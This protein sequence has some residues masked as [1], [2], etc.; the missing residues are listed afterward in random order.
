MEE[1]RKVRKRLYALPV[2]TLL[3]MMILMLYSH[4][5]V[6]AEDI[7]YPIAIKDEKVSKQ[8]MNDVFKDGGR[9]KFTPANEKE[10]AKLTLT[11]ATLESTN[12]VIDIDAMDGGLE[13]ICVGNNQIKS[14]EGSGIIA[15]NCNIRISGEGTLKIN[16]EIEAGVKS[17]SSIEFGCK[18]ITIN[19]SKDT[20]VKGSNIIITEGTLQVSASKYGIDGSAV[21]CGGISYIGGKYKAF[22]ENPDVSKY[23][24]GQ[25]LC[26]D[27]SSSTSPW[28]NQSELSNYR[29]V[30]VIPMIYNE[31][32]IPEN[33]TVAEGATPISTVTVPAGVSAEVAWTYY[34]DWKST[35][36]L[37]GTF[38]KETAYVCTITLKVDAKKVSNDV[39]IYVNNQMVSYSSEDSINEGKRIFKVQLFFDNNSENKY[40]K[41]GSCGDSC[42][43]NYNTNTKVLN[44]I[45][46]G[47]MRDYTSS[48]LA[49]ELPWYEYKD[50][51]TKVIIA[52]G[53][54]YIGENC[55]SSCSNLQ[56]VEFENG[57]VLNEIGE[58]AF[59]N[60][61]KLNNIG[62][63]PNTV[64]KLGVRAFYN[65]SSLS[66]FSMNTASK[67]TKIES[68]CFN[69]CRQL[70]EI[71]LPLS[72][73]SIGSSAFAHCTSLSNIEYVG[74]YYDWNK[75]SLGS[76]WFN[77]SIK[78]N[79][80]DNEIKSEH[81]TLS[82]YSYIY[83]GT[84]IKPSVTVT[85]NGKR[86][87]SYYDYNTVYSYNKDAG[88]A[89]VTISGRGNYKGSTQ[90][91]FTILQRDISNLS[92]YLPVS[93]YRADG[94]E[95][96]PY[97]VIKNG[98][99]LLTQNRDYCLTYSNNLLEGTGHIYIEGIGNYC[100]MTERTF[101]I[102][103]KDMAQLKLIL[104]QSSFV[105]DGA[106]KTPV[107]SV[108]DG[109]TTLTKDVDYSVTYTNN[110][111]AGTG[112]ATVTGRGKYAGTV[113]LPFKIAPKNFE[114]TSVSIKTLKYVYDG[115]AKCP[116]VTVKDGYKLLGKDTDYTIEYSNNMKPGTAYVKVIGKGNYS[117][118]KKI[119][120]T[121]EGRKVSDLDIELEEIVYDYTGKAIK[122]KVTVKDGAQT[123]KKGNDYSVKYSDNTDAGKA[124][125]TITGLGRYT[126][127]VK[128]T[129]IINPC[130][131]PTPTLFE[132]KFVYDGK[133]KTP[134]LL[135]GNL[136]LEEDVDY[137]VTLSSG[138][139]KVGTYTVFVEGTGNYTGS[140]F[141][142]FSIIPKST[143]TISITPRYKGFSMTWK[144]QPSQT[145]GYQI[146][147]S[148]YRNFKKYKSVKISDNSTTSQKITGLKRNRKCY[149]R[150]RT[151]KVVSGKTFYSNWSSVKTVT[152]K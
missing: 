84:Y 79:A 141:L 52:K 67:L 55:F 68:G 92:I 60:D 20:G 86:L 130:A 24:D 133:V 85:I 132:D 137:T 136:E 28:D 126:G 12:D 149:V 152:T 105:Y 102:T 37:V 71:R 50:S 101:Y 108:S 129:F 3:C 109:S 103:S 64:E 40:N 66:K 93:S 88:T 63:L 31:I 150:I 69:Y 100:G 48:K 11:N 1:R 33:I 41:N 83:D 146:Q 5:V 139:K 27:N 96:R 39:H 19:S 144:E 10:C 90:V 97:V 73:S 119:D 57:S 134:K 49:T 106:P 65:C 7:F 29:Y 43:W 135:W 95:K 77:G 45:G 87:S 54:T 6:M 42:T 46:S 140:T 26:G 75:V 114:N 16:T 47:K 22:H 104:S 36:P 25:V 128:K 111:K 138:R 13:I 44:I 30:K 145:K 116:E 110:V 56:T 76:G 127:T 131:L 117:G 14:T 8:N 4:S 61:S 107:V 59:F 113:N 123:L 18:N 81:V 74:T 70:K 120:F 122:P 94:T 35:E 17:D 89:F 62:E 125:L 2:L 21:F 98:S 118:T 34:K 147:Y 58:E 99:T 115:I 9:V 112:T 72:I 78:Y 148:Y 80:V 15:K 51:I 53:I 82:N 91:S 38:Q 142:E 143:S 23:V 32:R 151:Y 124:S 121:I